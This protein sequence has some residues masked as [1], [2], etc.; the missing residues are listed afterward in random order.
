MTKDLH[1]KKYA[2]IE[3]L[4][5]LTP[6]AVSAINDSGAQV[7]NVNPF[8][9]AQYRWLLTDDIVDIKSA[10]YG[11]SEE[12][13][14]W[15][16][17]VDSTPVLVVSGEKL[18]VRQVPYHEKEKRHFAKMLPYEIEDSVIDDVENLHFSIG[19]K[20]KGQ[21]TIAYIERAWFENA[22]EFFQQIGKPIER[23]LIDFQCLQREPNE[24]ILWFAQKRLLAHN[25][26][27]AGFAIADSLTDIF[28]QNMLSADPVALAEQDT[29][30]GSVDEN[31]QT[32]DL[33]Q[34][35]KIY[36]PSGDS[37][38]Y[39]IEKATRVVHTINPG[40]NSEFYDVE[41][42]LSLSN[43]NAIDFC[44]GIYAPKKNDSTQATSWKLI[45]GLSLFS[46][47]LFL[48]VNFFEIYIIQQKTSVTMKATEAS[49]RQVVPEGVVRDPVR[50]LRE[51][52]EKLTGGDGQPSE[53]VRLLS[54]VA[55][56][57][58]KLDI[59]LLT[60]NYSHKEKI[61]RLSVQASSFN[62]VEKL[63]T[64]IE[65]KGLTA[66]LL[67]SNA[68]DNKFQARLRISMGQF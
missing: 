5:F 50:K 26:G 45:G 7:E 9:N 11:S 34:Q 67:N 39:T 36:V 35:Y 52:L 64:D 10:I 28:L 65:E 37:A 4:S 25:E 23:A 46:I 20:N 14:G 2:Y 55:P 13:Q 60:I 29:K 56:V 47:L 41:P 3:C 49:Y 63:R 21:A 40:V 16:T 18:V 8:S 27:G 58:Q 1:L 32:G 44:T 38:T 54:H 59:D 68:V 43:I 6:E 66:E 62:M 22:L 17:A 53:V 33:A 57:I 48:S 51:M 42:P 12:L 19:E 61:L 24:S 31:D 30:I 15:L